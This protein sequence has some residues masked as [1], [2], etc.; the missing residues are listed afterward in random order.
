MP[1]DLRQVKGQKKK[2]EFRGRGGGCNYLKKSGLRR[3]FPILRAGFR[4]V[5]ETAKIGPCDR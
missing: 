4:G 5:S 1:N 2:R 3:S